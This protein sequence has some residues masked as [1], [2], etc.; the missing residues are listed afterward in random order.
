MSDKVWVLA[1]KYSDNSGS[2]VNPICYE[3]YTTAYH[4]CELLNAEHSGRHFYAVELEVF[5][6]E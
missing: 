2:G 1:W 6:N 3:D 4:I 5:K